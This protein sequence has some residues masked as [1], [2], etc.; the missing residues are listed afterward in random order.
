L[1]AFGA[2]VF[3]SRYPHLEGLDRLA[4]RSGVDIRPTL[5]RV[6]TDLYLQKRSH[7]AEEER[8]YTEL[9][10]R[11]LDRVDVATRKIVA[12]KLAHYSLAP[13]AVV[14]R[15]ARDVLEVAEPVL[16]HSP[17]LTGS[18]L[19]AIITELG[20]AYAAVIARRLRIGVSAGPITNEHRPR[21]DAIATSQ[22]EAHPVAS[23]DRRPAS[24]KEDSALNAAASLE[25][26]LRLGLRF[27]AA[28]SAE[29]RAILLSL[30][31]VAD[32]P[33]ACSASQAGEAIR[34]LEAAALQ[35]KPAEFMRT[36]ERTLGLAPQHAH[37]IVVDESG[38]PLVVC[39]KALGMPPPAV[40]RILLFLNPTIGQSV[41]RVF[42][43]AKLYDSISPQAA[44]R[45]IASLRSANATRR[46]AAYRPVL[47]ADTPE[48]GLAPDAA[49]RAA[50]RM[51][52]GSGMQ[53]SAFP[54]SRSDKVEKV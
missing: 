26:Q 37:G 54:A 31:D 51:P 47:S 46:W 16:L 30:A 38:E 21:T 2:A 45:L 12:G 14:R 53:P 35:R 43:L 25:T 22:D 24:E 9:V 7:T 8:H 17:R 50:G 44:L 20:P 6:L 4:L 29:R 52:P 42:D 40:L 41:T 48:R 27:L 1:V 5:V 3:Q 11:L 28:S 33:S 34:R 10:L 39:L 18:E 36:L 15:L 19:L 32:A 23:V 49:R 13:A